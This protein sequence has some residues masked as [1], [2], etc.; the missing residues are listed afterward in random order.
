MTIE[1]NLPQDACAPSAIEYLPDREPNSKCCVT[2]A[3]AAAN[4][5]HASAKKL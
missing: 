5:R 3:R 2:V 4:G 1:A